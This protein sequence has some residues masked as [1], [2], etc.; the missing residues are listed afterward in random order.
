MAITF[1]GVLFTDVMQARAVCSLN[2]KQSDKE[3]KRS[4]CRR[5]SGVVGPEAGE[6]SLEPT[7]VNRRALLPLPSDG[8]RAGVR[9]ENIE[10]LTFV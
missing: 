6:K 1:E 7:F 5:G 3:D 9:D 8:K 2:L 10:R 4:D